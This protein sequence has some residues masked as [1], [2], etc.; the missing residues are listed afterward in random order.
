MSFNENTHTNLYFDTS[1]CLAPNCYKKGDN[2]QCKYKPKNNSVFCGKHKTSKH[3]LDEMILSPMFIDDDEDIDEDINEKKIDI[4][5]K[6]IDKNEKVY[7]N[8]K[9]KDIKRIKNKKRKKKNKKKYKTNRLNRFHKD[10]LDYQD[11]IDIDAIYH[12]DL[13]NTL[14]Y[15]NISYEG[16]KKTLF[17]KLKKYYEMIHYYKKHIDKIVIIQKTIRKQMIKIR[18]Q[19]KGLGFYVRNVCNNQT[20][21]FTLENIIDIHDDYFFSY[22]DSDGF[23]YGFDIRSFYKLVNTSGVN[24]Y[25][26]NEIP[27]KTIKRM[28]QRILQMKRQMISLEENGDEEELQLTEKQKLNIEVMNVFQKIDDLNTAAGG[29][30]IQWFTELSIVL[31][32]IFYKELED[33]WNYRAQLSNEAKKRIIP[34]GNIFRLSVYSMY[35]IYDIYKVRYIIL[36]E[37]DKLVSLG[38]TEADRNLGA[39]WILTALTIVSPECASALPWL[40]QV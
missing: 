22:K 19:Y 27:S 34:N 20:D 39:L 18:N 1:R 14:R 9:S 6:K 36:K 37:M 11:L 5:E 31:L 28:R 15:F 26:R 33:I 35:N 4:N 3:R 8:K 17:I 38:V 2:T 13:I 21:F 24:P 12:K 10:I 29:T 30:D 7:L 32:K 40:V 23:I 16:K 25:N